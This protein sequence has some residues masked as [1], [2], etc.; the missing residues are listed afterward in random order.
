MEKLE[1]IDRL[2]SDVEECTRKDRMYE[3]YLSQADEDISREQ[4]Q[5][6]EGEIKT[7][8]RRKKDAEKELISV[9]SEKDEKFQMETNLRLELK[10]NQEFIALEE[11]KKERE[12]LKEEESQALSEK[13]EL[14]K[15]V[16]KALNA[17]YRLLE[18]RDVDAC[19]REYERELKNLEKTHDIART[20]EITE[21][22]MKYKGEMFGKV[23]NKLAEVNTRQKRLHEEKQELKN[24]IERLERKNYLI[25]RQ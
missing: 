2:H 15:S 1:K 11:Q 23:Q 16:K 24:K 7:E 13:R 3:F 22:V 10:Q 9:T 14:Q 8:E 25:H 20:R 4:I 21:R 17:A 5:R 12:R 19:V 6:L 18:V